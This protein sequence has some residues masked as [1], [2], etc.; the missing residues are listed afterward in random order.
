MFKSIGLNIDRP[1]TFFVQQGK[2][3]KIVNFKPNEALEMLL[4]AAGVAYFREVAGQTQGE[5]DEKTGRL[6]ITEERMNATF[7]PKLAQLERDKKKLHEFEAL[8]SEIDSLGNLLSRLIKYNTAKNLTQLTRQLH[9]KQQQA[10]ELKVHLKELEAQRESILYEARSRVSLGE[11][12]DGAAAS[13]LEELKEKKTRLVTSRANFE[14]ESTELKFQD[15]T[16][17]QKNGQLSKLE[18]DRA[19][20]QSTFTSVSASHRQLQSQ[21]EV[22]E[23]KLQSADEEINNIQIQSV[24]NGSAAEASAPIQARLDKC[25]DRLFTIDQKEKERSQQLV[26]WHQEIKERN[27][28]AQQDKKHKADKQAE[29]KKLAAE[30]EGLQGKIEKFQM[31]ETAVKETERQLSKLTSEE[32]EAQAKLAE[33]RLRPE[34]FELSYRVGFLLTTEPIFWIRSKPGAR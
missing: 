21:Q 1:E 8:K 30:L 4:E 27:A 12:G 5:L 2:I 19:A 31:V 20:F 25:K 34:D 16:F 14:K 13:M 17:N 15:E 23:Q 28:E 32:R 26:R 11:E 9:S 18:K 3:T 29:I 24:S 6:A 7:G 22:L 33:R 10:V